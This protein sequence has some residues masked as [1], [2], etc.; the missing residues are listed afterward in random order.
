[1]IDPRLSQGLAVFAAGVVAA[2][3][4]RWGYQPAV[5]AY[6]Q[7]QQHVESLSA[8]VGQ[9]EAMVQAAGGMEAWHAH[10]LKR[11]EFLRTR[12]PPPAQVPQLLNALVETVKVGDVKLLNVS[13]GN[14]EAVQD[15]GQPLLVGGQPCY[16]LP[17]TV[18]AEGRY[19]LLV[20]ALDR[21]TAETFPSVVGIERAE[22]RLKDPLSAQLTATLRLSLYVIGAPSEPA[23][24]A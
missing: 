9:V 3:S 20:Q 11:L 6:R 12:F 23:P 24:D 18:T 13:Q 14:V 2:T 10:H 8:R 4:W 7:D 22:F 19:H 15:A 21:I 5:R 17:V 1:M 16:R